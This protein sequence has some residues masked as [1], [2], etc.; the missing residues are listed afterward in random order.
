V[1]ANIDTMFFVSTRPFDLAAA[2]FLVASLIDGPW[3]LVDA[4]ISLQ[5]A[6]HGCLS[7]N[8]IGVFSAL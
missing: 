5:Q 1:K 7:P 3:Y 2:V 6:A 8:L 4:R